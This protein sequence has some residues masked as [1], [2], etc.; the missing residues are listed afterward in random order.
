MIS[1]CGIDPVRIVKQVLLGSFGQV[2]SHVDIFNETS[3]DT[4]VV[5]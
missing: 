5:A 4:T 3:E 1:R 2:H